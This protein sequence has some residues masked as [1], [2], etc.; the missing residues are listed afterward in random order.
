MRRLI[1]TSIVTLAVATLAAQQVTRT[2][3]PRLWTDEALSGWALPIAGVNATPSFYTEAE[4]YAAPVDEL[5]TYPV[6]L[7]GREPKGYRDWMRRQ[8]PQPLIEIGKARSDAEW[9]EAGRRM[10]DGFDLPENRTDDSRVLAWLD[11]PAAERSGQPVDGPAQGQTQDQDQGRTQATP[12]S[13]A[14]Q[15]ENHGRQSS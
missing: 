9:V 3:A 1:A 11:D 8:G 15:P 5:R 13:E 7:K 2:R 14:G 10:F 4:Y 12:D 6:Y